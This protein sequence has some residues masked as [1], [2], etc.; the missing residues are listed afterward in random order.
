MR[1][2]RNPVKATPPSYADCYSNP[3]TP[4][5]R[6]SCRRHRYCHAFHNQI[7]CTIP[8]LESWQSQLKDKYLPSLIFC[9][10]S[11]LPFFTPACWEVA[12]PTSQRSSLHG[13]ACQFLIFV[14]SLPPGLEPPGTAPSDTGSLTRWQ[15]LENKGLALRCWSRQF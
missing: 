14:L 7:T 10:L 15:F 1:S 5:H 8:L 13:G 11:S 3:P 4:A 2:S 12:A 6:R 9:R